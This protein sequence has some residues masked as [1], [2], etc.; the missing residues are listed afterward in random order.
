MGLGFGLGVS[1]NGPN[2]RFL[3]FGLGLKEL[4]GGQRAAGRFNP[5]ARLSRERLL[6]LPSSS[7]FGDGESREW[8]LRER[9]PSRGLVASR[10]SQPRGPPV[11]R[12]GEARRLLTGQGLQPQRLPVS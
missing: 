7:I 3:H 11:R 6:I 12:K 9:V 1:P 2:R 4:Q 10:R 5:A 8:R